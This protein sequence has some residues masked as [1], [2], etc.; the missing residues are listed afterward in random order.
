MVGGGGGGGGGGGVRVIIG[1]HLFNIQPCSNILKQ[2]KENW[3]D[4][5]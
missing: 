1:G 5:L 3:V 4:A 2:R